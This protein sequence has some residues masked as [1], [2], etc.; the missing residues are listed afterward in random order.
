MPDTM[1]TSAGDNVGRKTA[2]EQ[3]RFSMRGTRL[4]SGGA[5]MDCVGSTDNLWAHAK[6]YSSGGEN[7]LHAHAK[8]DHCFLV[9][10]GRATFHFGD[11]S[12]YVAS[13]Y[14][15]VFLPKGTSYRFQAHAGENL[16]LFRVGGAQVS[17]PASVDPV[18]GMPLELRGKR[19]GPDGKALDGMSAKNGT[20]SEATVYAEGAFFPKE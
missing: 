20:P 4:L 13:P 9:L 15:G 18:S 10:Q 14:E 7:A 17:N 19:L 5:T 2:A 6:V 16:V 8:E 12:S 3:A 11:G 1:M